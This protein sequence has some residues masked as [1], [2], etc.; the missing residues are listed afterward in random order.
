MVWI[1]IIYSVWA[2]IRLLAYRASIEGFCKYLVDH[3]D[4]DDIEQ[5]DLEEYTKDLEE[6]MRKAIRSWFKK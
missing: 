5:K 2:T 4:F 6:Y 1:L 3:Y